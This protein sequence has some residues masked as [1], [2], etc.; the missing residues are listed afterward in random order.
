MSVSDVDE[1]RHGLQVV[2]DEL[3]KKDELL[4]RRDELIAQARSQTPP[5]TLREVA[6]LLGM[7]ERGVSKALDAYLARQH[8]LAS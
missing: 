8:R 2:A 4:G 1:I 3:A 7:T 5:M 6:R